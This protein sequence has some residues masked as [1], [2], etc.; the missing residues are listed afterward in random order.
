[1]PLYPREWFADAG[2]HA[3][4]FAGA[5]PPALTASGMVHGTNPVFLSSLGAGAAGR[6]MG[7]GIGTGA[8]MSEDLPA[9]LALLEYAFW[10]ERLLAGALSA[11]GSLVQ[12]RY[13]DQSP[14]YRTINVAL[15]GGGSKVITYL[16]TA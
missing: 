5:G 13:I 15:A 11:R 2:A 1:M 12:T 4:P 16:G 14:T 8:V 6:G 7:M 9:R 3:M 10:T